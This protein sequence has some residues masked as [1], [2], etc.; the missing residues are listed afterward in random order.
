MKAAAQVV[1]L[2]EFNRLLAVATEFPSRLFKASRFQITEENIDFNSHFL[3]WMLSKGQALH[4][5]KI[6]PTRQEF[7]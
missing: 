1:E 2:G 3:R 5:L 6:S 4:F 7:P